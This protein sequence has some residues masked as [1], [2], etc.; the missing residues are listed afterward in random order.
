MKLKP[1]W[2]DTA[3][4]CIGTAE[5][6]PNGS[7]DVVIVGAGFTGLSA[8]LALAKKGA[9]VLPVVGAYYRFKDLIG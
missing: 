3:P 9:N 4:P 2:L 7:A 1:Y 6:P 8:A 5:G